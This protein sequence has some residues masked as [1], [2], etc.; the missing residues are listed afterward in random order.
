MRQCAICG[1]SNFALAIGPG[2]KKYC[3]PAEAGCFDLALAA[4]VEGDL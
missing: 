4:D 1:Q 2:G 3:P